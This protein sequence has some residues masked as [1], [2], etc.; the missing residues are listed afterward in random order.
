MSLAFT[1]DA[2]K[3]MRDDYKKCDSKWNSIIRYRDAFFFFFCRIRGAC[4][5]TRHSD[6]VF[7]NNWHSLF[8]G[9]TLNFMTNFSMI[10]ALG[11]LVD[12]AIVIVEGIH[13]FI[14]S[15]HS[16]REAA[17]HS[18]REFGAPLISG[19]LTTVAVF[20]PLLSLSGVLGQYLSFIPIT[21]IIVLV[22][23]LAI[24]YSCFRRMLHFC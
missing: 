10:L 2:A 13:H 15:G 5:I 18:L 20:I 23:S 11:I 8:T 21:V 4:R 1:N 22:V 24:F 12:T 7:S 17:L 19:T 9:R 6:Y 14:R 16:P 3:N